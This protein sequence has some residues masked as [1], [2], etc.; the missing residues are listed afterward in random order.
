MVTKFSKILLVAIAMTVTESCDPPEQFCDD[1]AKNANIANLYSLQPIQEIY[2]KGDE[3]VF[4]MEIPS[5]NNFFGRQIDIY[6]ETMDEKPLVSGDDGLFLGNSIQFVKGEQGQYPN[7]FF[8]E[9]ENGTY[10]LEFA[11]ILKR[12]GDYFFYNSFR[13]VFIGNGECNYYDIETYILN[14]E[15]NVEVRFEVVE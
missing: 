15:G 7:Q 12:T 9:L 11:V 10:Y 5:V 8:M 4:K 14:S 13:V 2:Q 3:I 1:L 6:E